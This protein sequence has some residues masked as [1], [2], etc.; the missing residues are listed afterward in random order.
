MPNNKHLVSIC[1]PTFNR[2]KEL[3]RCI[4]SLIEQPE[5]LDN[6]VEIV[7]SDNASTDN[8]AEKMRYYVN[9]F[10]NFSYFRNEQNILDKNF[11]FVLM[12]A[13]GVLRK[14]NN[15]T[16][17]FRKGSL[18]Y[19]CTI[20]E[21]YKQER[22]LLFWGNGKLTKNWEQENVIENKDQLVNEI[23]T[24]FPWIGAYSF[25]ESDCQFFMESIDRCDTH[26]WQVWKFF[27][28]LEVSNKVIILN[29]PLVDIYE[30]K[31]KKEVGYGLFQ[32]FYKNYLDILKEYQKRGV[33][34]PTTVARV[35]KALLFN[36][37]ED[38]LI[39]WKLHS[40]Q[41][42]YNTT[43]DLEKALFDAYKMKPYFGE[44]Q[45]EYKIKFKKQ[46]FKYLLKNSSLGPSL[47]EIKRMLIRAMGG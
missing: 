22:P 15:D 8:S 43:E 31:R 1:I 44:F 5:F 12:K 27:E 4:N 46:R 17:V 16:S 40:R 14:I 47:I 20:A 18:K 7:V 34:L 29:N 33:I 3:L 42:I 10:S 21:K 19:L 30:V 28:I 41:Y 13:T 26:L 25:W 35:E 6:R 39:A 9:K 32:V 11:P 24:L 45:K 37:F 2:E 38:M 23:G 36:F